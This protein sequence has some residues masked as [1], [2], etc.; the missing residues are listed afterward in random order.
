MHK[1]TV[2]DV[3]LCYNKVSEDTVF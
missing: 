2:Y 1:I 3:Y